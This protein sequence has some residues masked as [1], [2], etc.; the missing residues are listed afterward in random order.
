MVYFESRTVFHTRLVSPCRAL[1][2]G[3]W[4]LQ[5]S[6]LY[7][8]LPLID[9]LSW[10]S[11][12]FAGGR[13]RLN[14]FAIY[15]AI[16]L[17]SDL[18]RLRLCRSTLSTRILF[19]LVRPLPHLSDGWASLGLTVGLSNV[20]FCIRLTLSFPHVLDLN[21]RGFGGLRPQVALCDCLQSP[22]SSSFRFAF[23]ILP[24]DVA[25]VLLGVLPDLTI[26]F[27]MAS[28]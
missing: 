15:F 12:H 18:G 6:P 27:G 24:H 26:S 10:S 22:A 14:C 25:M 13:S 11:R 28:L 9:L 21:S 19:L 5:R 1:G 23:S 17:Y 16:R 20:F 8:V 2:A 4:S 3:T 7:L